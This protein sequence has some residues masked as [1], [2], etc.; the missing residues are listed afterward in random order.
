MN[1][2]ARALLE[3]LFPTGLEHLRA[4]VEEVRLPAG[5]TVFRRGD[6]CRN[7]LLVVQGSVRVQ[8][9]A[10]NGREITLYRVRDGQSCVITTACLISVEAYPAEGVTEVETDALVVPQPVFEQALGSS[11][12]FRRFVFANQGQRLGDLIRRVEDVVFGR[13]DV[14]LARLLMTLS[15]QGVRPIATTHQQLASELG[16]AREVISRQLKQFAGR[17]WV[18]LGRGVIEVKMPAALDELARQSD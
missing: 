1:R 17:G 11:A 15:E 18:G 4:R 8:V 2:A 3:R 10:A 6:P 12:E 16:S 13:I 5:Q 14:R 7:Y 9:L